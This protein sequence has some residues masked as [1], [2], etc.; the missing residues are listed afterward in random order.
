M[1]ELTFKLVMLGENSSLISSVNQSQTAAVAVFN[2]IKDE[3]DKLRQSSEQTAEDVGKIRRND[4]S[5]F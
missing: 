4:N 3:A 2:K 5:V 1:S